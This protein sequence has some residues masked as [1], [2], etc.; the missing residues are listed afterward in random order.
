MFRILTILLALMGMTQIRL[1]QCLPVKEAGVS[2]EAYDWRGVYM[3]SKPNFQGTCH[4][5]H[6]AP[7]VRETCIHVEIPGSK[8]LL[9]IASLGPDWGLGVLM[10]DTPDCSSTRGHPGSITQLMVCPGLTSLNGFWPDDQPK[11]D[12]YIKVTDVHPTQQAHAGYGGASAQCPSSPT[13]WRR[14][15]E[16]AR[17]KAI[18]AVKKERI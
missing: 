10:F 7:N 11:R 6:V 12:L 14:N 4:W 9:P 17:A 8:D 18:E 1:V 5:H 3:C 15:M 2:Q 13:P 16:E